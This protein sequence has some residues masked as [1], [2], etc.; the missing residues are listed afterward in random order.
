ML[1]HF[2]EMIKNKY[3]WATYVLS[4]LMICFLFYFQWIIGLLFVF[5]LVISL[6]YDIKE[7]KRLKKKQK[8]YISNLSYQVENAGKNVFLN[9][10]IGIIIYDEAYEVEWVNPY[11]FNINDR[12]SV[13]GKSLEIFSND[14]IPQIKGN[15]EE[16]WLT[17]N[18]LQFKTK[19]DAENRILFLFNRTEEKQ[20]EK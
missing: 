3:V 9:M 6:F 12:V 15:K 13:L 18:H 11:I 16:V 2:Q 17:I 14:L 7:E 10:P 20:L 19:I 4:F 1:E 5:L 8:N